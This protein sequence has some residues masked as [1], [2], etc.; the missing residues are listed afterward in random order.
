M[1]FAVAFK[2]ETKSTIQ[3]QR[4]GLLPRENEEQGR[5][6]RTLGLDIT[7]SSNVRRLNELG[8]FLGSDGGSD[9]LRSSSS[10]EEH[11]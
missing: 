5:G 6:E 2:H 10:S 9:F 3:T 11:V 4:S 8:L 1:S 7:L